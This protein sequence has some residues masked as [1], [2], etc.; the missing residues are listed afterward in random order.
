M[1]VDQVIQ[2]LGADPNLPRVVGVRDVLA[3]AAR[4]HRL[5]INPRYRPLVAN[6]GDIPLTLAEGSDA[7]TELAT[8]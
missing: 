3:D 5:T 4:R 7:V 8:R 2:Q 6:V 1:T